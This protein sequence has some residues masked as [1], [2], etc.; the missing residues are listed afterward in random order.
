PVR[1]TSGAANPSSAASWPEALDGRADGFIYILRPDGSSSIVADALKLPNGLAISA[2]KRTLFC[3][4][5]TDADVLAEYGIMINMCGPASR[6]GRLKLAPSE[7]YHERKRDFWSWPS[8]ARLCT[9]LNS[10]GRTSPWEE[11][12]SSLQS[13]NKMN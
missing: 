11:T 1:A 6:E 5:T 13:G 3:C 8:R 2:D 7:Q 9:L 10:P 12:R 4:Q